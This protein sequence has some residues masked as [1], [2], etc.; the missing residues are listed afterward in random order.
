MTRAVG[1]VTGKMGAVNP[2]QFVGG[3]ELHDV[4]LRVAHVR[5][6]TTGQWIREHHQRAGIRL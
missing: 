4:I 1:L 2:D 6:G 5:C 3:G